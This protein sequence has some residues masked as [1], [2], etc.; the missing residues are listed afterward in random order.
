MRIAA[1]LVI[2][3]L[4]GGLAYGVY[5]LLT[6]TDDDD[7]DYGAGSPDLL[8]V[9]P[10]DPERC[11][12][13]PTS[14]ERALEILR[15]V[16]VD[17]DEALRRSTM[18][19]PVE[20]DQIPAGELNARFTAWQACRRFGLTYQAMTLQAP[21]FTREDF[22]GEDTNDFRGPVETAYSD[23]ALNE[24]LD[25]REELDAT[26]YRYWETL[27]FH[28]D[29][30]WTLILAGEAYTS[31]DQKFIAIRAMAFDVASD[32]WKP[33]PTVVVFQFLD[34]Q[35]LLFDIQAIPEGAVPYL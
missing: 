5:P 33:T 6:D 28:P 20:P 30:T 12:S 27:D 3:V 16:D 19:A 2:L 35:F 23:A 4:A 21:Y 24:L 32:A 25:R 34:G 7:P 1:I 22:Y 31:P 18:L 26:S 8:F 10:L 29:P 11:A 15:D 13:A 9:Q 14:R 17:R